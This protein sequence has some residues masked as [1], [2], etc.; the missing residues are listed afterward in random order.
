MLEIKRAELLNELLKVSG[1]DSVLITGAPG[2]GKSWLIG[3]FLK[4]LKRSGRFFL[5][6][7]AEDFQVETVDELTNQVGLGQ[8]IPVLFA[9]RGEGS[10]LIVDGLDALRGES[11]QRVFRDLLLEVIA[12]SPE[13][14]VVATIR[15]FDLAESPIFVALSGNFRGAQ[16]PFRSMVVGPLNDQ[17]ISSLHATSSRFEQLWKAANSDTREMLRNP[18][19]LGIALAL[20]RE[21]TSPDELKL[22]GSQ[23]RLLGEYWKS[24]VDSASNAL[25][26]KRLLRDLLDQMILLRLLSIAETDISDKVSADTLFALLSAEVLRKGATGRLSFSHNILFDYA[27]ARLLLDEVKFVPFVRDD[28]ARALYYRPSLDF[29]FAY[30]WIEDRSIFWNTVRTLFSAEGIPESTKIIPA[31]V[32]CH[33]ADTVKALAPL[34][35]GSDAD[36]SRKLLPKVLLGVQVLGMPSVNRRVVWLSLLEQLSKQPSLDFINEIFDVFVLLQQSARPAERLV[37][38]TSARRLIEWSWTYGKTLPESD[39]ANLSSVMTARLLRVV[40]ATFDADSRKNAKF[41]RQILARIG[42]PRAATGELFWLVNDIGT[43]IEMEPELAASIFRAVYAYKETSEEKTQMGTG[44]V[45]NLTSTRRQDYEGMR[46]TLGAK[47]ELLIERN[48]TLAASTAVFAVNDEVRSERPLNEGQSLQQISIKAIGHRPI[49]YIAD[50]SEIWDSSSARD[51]ISLQ[52]LDAVL[53]FAAG[54][55]SVEIRSTIVEALIGGASV[56]VVYKHVLE[57]ASRSPVVFYATVGI[58]TK[59]PRFISAPE[60]SVAVGEFLK[61]ASAADLINDAD[62]KEI[63]LAILR[64]GRCRPLLRYEKPRSIQRRLLSCLKGDR[65]VDARSKALLADKEKIRENR[66][67]YSIQG[68]FRQ[69]SNEFLRMRGIDPDEANNKLL[70]ESTNTVRDFEGQHQ[71]KIPTSEQATKALNGFLALRDAIQSYSGTNQELLDNARGHLLAAVETVLRIADLPKESELFQ[72]CREIALEGSKDPNPVFDERYHLPFDHPGWGS[73]SSRIEAAQAVSH[74]VW[75]YLPDEDAF[76]EFIKLSKDT[77][78][79]VRF[80]IT[81]GL[82]GL[83]INESERNRFW[84]QLD[85]MF[86]AETTNGVLVGLMDTLHRVAGQEPER[87]ISTL[88]KF[89]GRERPK[90]E[91]SDV[92]RVAL[93]ILVGL[94]V[95]RSLNSAQQELLFFER[96]IDRYYPE[97]SQEIILAAQYLSPADSEDAETRAR[98]RAVWKR[99]IAAVRLGAVRQA[100]L[101]NGERNLM[102][103]ARV[104]DTLAARLYFVFDLIGHRAPNQKEMN[105]A[106]R[107]Q[108]YQ[109]MKEI[110]RDVTQASVPGNDQAVPL[111]PHAAH[112]LLQLMNGILQFDPRRVLIDASA[113]CRHGARTGYLM[114]SLARTEAVKLVERAIADHREIIREAPVAEAV[115]GMLNLFTAAGWTEAV[116]LVFKLDRAFR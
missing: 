101:P 90:S 30:L 57:S 27:V 76:R 84:N 95:V 46:Y 72:F 24:R 15:T 110:I 41:I 50:Y 89:L 98:A 78:P 111:V 37:L 5:A 108:L 80:Q 59:I 13:T 88:H 35:S 69:D 19:N 105:D 87:S 25:G 20:L 52:M 36:V 79:A 85:E 60:V 109:E 77:V 92:M 96:D 73:P 61:A 75:N 38:T 53:R 106:E 86:A 54:E 14:H 68:G 107:A 114:D 45:L 103:I 43:I 21:G 39:A 33:L 81:R 64:I 7:V 9:S 113:I 47:F 16:N 93:D 58:L 28:P 65:L 22:I 83:F 71:N 23:V 29:F 67:F 112:Y 34:Y 62:Y 48:P 97:L 44:S 26:K 6:L 1:T 115:G 100:L 104:M 56:A 74:L 63:E 82:L 99:V 40:I 31:V 91:R 55:L 18:F 17:E 4:E 10:V 32:V 2:I 12:A 116:A 42:T 49:T 66:P 102:P 51:Y 70:L 94:E 3:E 8:S 11:S